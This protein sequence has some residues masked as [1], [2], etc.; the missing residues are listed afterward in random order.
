[1]KCRIYKDKLV[2]H[3]TK[4]FKELNFKIF[5]KLLVLVCKYPSI[6]KV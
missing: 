6:F 1:M 5:S 2:M 3:I 4:R